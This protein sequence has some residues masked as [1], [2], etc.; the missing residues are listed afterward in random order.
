MASR[1]P[2][3]VRNSENPGRPPGGEAIKPKKRRSPFPLLDRAT[4]LVELNMILKE[5][6]SHGYVKVSEEDLKEPTVSLEEAG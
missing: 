2:L 6:M 4:L 1:R 3:S 5:S